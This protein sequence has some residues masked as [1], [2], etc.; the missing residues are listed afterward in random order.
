MNIIFNS[1][2]EYTSTNTI[3]GNAGAGYNINKPTIPEIKFNTSTNFKVGEYN[4]NTMP[5]LPNNFTN[6]Y[7][8]FYNTNN[9]INGKSWVCNQNLNSNGSMKRSYNPNPWVK[10]NLEDSFIPNTTPNSQTFAYNRKSSFIDGSTK[11]QWGG[12]NNVNISDNNLEE[13][14]TRQAIQPNEQTEEQI[15]EKENALNILLEE[16][17]S[18]VENTPSNYVYN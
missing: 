15:K 18:G 10:Y 6:N 11:R 7:N 16:M 3:V 9:P 4:N 8:L 1:E 17:N 12:F 2:P 13:I 14:Q 5:N